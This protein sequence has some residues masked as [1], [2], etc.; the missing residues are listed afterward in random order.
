M[1]NMGYCRFENT[2]RDLE[3]CYNHL[4]DDLEGMEKANRL[5]LVKLC[6]QIIEAW[7]YDN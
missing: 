7:N 4:D 5:A 6:E 3:D 2:V 1:A